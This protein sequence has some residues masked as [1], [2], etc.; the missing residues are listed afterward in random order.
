MV[1]KQILKNRIIEAAWEL[2]EEKGYEATTMNDII[3]K[4]QVARGSFY[5]YFKG[6]ESLLDTLATVFDNKYREIMEEI[7]SGTSVFNTLMILNFETHTFIEKHIDHKLLGNMYASQLTNTEASKLLDKDRYY[8]T[9]LGELLEAGQAN[10][11]IT[12]EFSVSELVNNYVILERAL[13][14]DWCMKN[15]SFSL[16]EYSKKYMPLFFGEFRVK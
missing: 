7:P 8:F 16:A 2:F 15:G 10:G 5:Y 1:K 11:E 14:S 12:T 3:E 9:L 6:K 4:A 13:V